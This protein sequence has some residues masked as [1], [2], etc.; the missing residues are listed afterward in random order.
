M[1]NRPIHQFL[2]ALLVMLLAWPIHVVA[3]EELPD[4]V[5]CDTVAWKLYETGKATYYSSRMHGRKVASGERYDK[6]ALS[7]AHKKL[8]FGTRIRVVNLRNGK[9]IVVV[10]Q[11]RGP[12]GR[13]LVVDLSYRAAAEL[14]MVRAGVVPVELWIEDN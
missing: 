14:D 11:D 6:N 2:S 8:P 4:T 10:V 12:F 13:G 7:C 9:E 1:K 5:S 3:H